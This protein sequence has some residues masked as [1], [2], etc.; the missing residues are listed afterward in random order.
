M[1]AYSGG[2][3]QYAKITMTFSSSSDVGS[4]ML[5]VMTSAGGLTSNYTN[6]SNYQHMNPVSNSW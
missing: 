4:A 2:A 3:N 1:I 6:F 5:F